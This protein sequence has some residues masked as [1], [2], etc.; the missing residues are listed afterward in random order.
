MLNQSLNTL[1][2]LAE[3]SKGYVV[4]AYSF[5]YTAIASVANTAS[6]DTTVASAAITLG[7]QL[8][9]FAD[10]INDNNANSKDLKE[11]I[12]TVLR[13]NGSEVKALIDPIA[14]D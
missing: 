6:T 11:F 3:A 7:N 8:K 5:A 14:L 9:K 12:E 13:D 2:R 1:G 4:S 10:K